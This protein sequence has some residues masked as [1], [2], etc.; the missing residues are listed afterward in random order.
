[1][2]CMKELKKTLGGGGDPE[3]SATKL[4]L[5]QAAYMFTCTLNP[6][7]CKGHSFCLQ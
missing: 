2:I 5:P 6:A 3:S 1:M 7:L 4:V